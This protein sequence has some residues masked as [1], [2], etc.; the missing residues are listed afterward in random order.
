MNLFKSRVKILIEN[1]DAYGLNKLLFDNPNMANRGITIPFDSTCKLKAH[2]LHRLCDAV[3]SGKITEL[4]AIKLAQVFLENGADIDGYKGI[5]DGSPLLAAA[6]LHAEQVGIFYIDNGADVHYT[7]KNDGASALHWAAFCGRDKLVERLIKA[8][9]EI[10]KADKEFNSTP[11][12][13]AIHSLQSNDIGNKHNQ[14]KCIKQLLI[15]GATSDLLDKDKYEY[16]LGLS[17]NNPDL[18]NLLV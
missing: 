10:N 16:L 18:L 3:F 12:G 1:N 7:N 8:G 9:A 13:W 15:N 11:L 5:D 6:S 2:P 4:E 17:K 14:L